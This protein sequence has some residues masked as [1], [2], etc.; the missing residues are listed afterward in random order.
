M[1]HRQAKAKAFELFAANLWPP[2]V[3]AELNMNIRTIQRW[4]IDWKAANVAT[5]QTPNS[6]A[7]IAAE[8]NRV[9]EETPHLSTVKAARGIAEWSQEWEQSA[10]ALNDELLL[11]HRKIRLRFTQMIAEEWSKPEKNMRVL[12]GLSQGIARHSEIEISVQNLG[13]LDV[14]KASKVLEAHGYVVLD[15]RFYDSE[16]K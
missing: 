6:S 8:S 3:A 15:P 4:F 11:H 7:D 2:D 1:A 5:S 12:T 9:I 16:E 13:L 14:S 10:V